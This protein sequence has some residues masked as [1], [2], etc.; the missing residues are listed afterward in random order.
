MYPCRLYLA[1][2]ECICVE[3]WQQE[4][5]AGEVRSGDALEV[6]VVR[7]R[8][9]RDKSWPIPSP[10]LKHFGPL[11]HYSMVQH[12]SLLEHFSLFTHSS[13]L[14]HFSLIEHFSLL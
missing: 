8:L 10:T 9:A 4:V 13:L 2:S 6:R 1:G 3:P 7:P 14:E 11:E 5:L 12:F